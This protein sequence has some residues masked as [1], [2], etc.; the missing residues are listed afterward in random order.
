MASKRSVAAVAILMSVGM[1]AC[2]LATW[3]IGYFLDASEPPARA[4][5]IVVLGGDGDGFMRTRHALDLYAAGYAPMVAFSGGTRVKAGLARSNAQIAAAMAG[6]LGLP[7]DA[8][9]VMPDS[10]S[11]RDEA[12]ALEQLARE[13]G[14]T[15]VIVV[16]DRFHTR[17]AGN[18]LRALAPDVS[19]VL[20]AAEDPRFDPK[21]WWQSKGGRVSVVSEVLKL[22][23][24]WVTYG[25]A[26]WG[27][28]SS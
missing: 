17:R 27:S 9:V 22:G 10:Y 7:Q 13:R 21:R 14:W 6:Q 16:T 20:S 3:R 5:A 1:M 2:L 23:Y 26:P 11:T 4:N 19:I 18:T 24:Y 15:S 12:V 28:S 8:T 25:I